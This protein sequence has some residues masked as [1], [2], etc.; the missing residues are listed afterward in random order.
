M[1]KRYANLLTGI[2]TGAD[3]LIAGL[4]FGVS[5]AIWEWQFSPLQYE[6]R[7]F[8][9]SGVLLLLV[10]IVAWLVV[11]DRFHLYSSKR[12]TKLRREYL[13]IAKVTTISIAAGALVVLLLNPLR[14][15]KTFLLIFWLIDTSVLGVSRVVIRGSLRTLR[16]LGYNY[17]N[18]VIIGTNNRSRRLG[19][20]ITDNRGYGLHLLGYIDDTEGPH[21]TPFVNDDVTIIGN[22]KEFEDVLHRYVIDEVYITLPIKSFYKRI[23]EIVALCEECGVPVRVP[24]DL[25]RLKVATDSFAVLDDIPL[26]DISSGPRAGLSF[27][28]KRLI[29]IAVSSFLLILLSPLLLLVALLIKLTSVGPVL[30]RQE[31]L[32]LNRRPFTLLKFRS[33]VADAESMRDELDHLN[34]VTGPVFKIRDDPRITRMG[35]FL[36]KTSLD[37]LPQLFNVLKGEMSLVGPRPPIPAEVEHYDWWQQRRLSMRPGLTCLWQVGGRSDTP[38]REWVNLDLK[39]IDNWSLKLDLA[40]MLRTIPAVIRGNGAA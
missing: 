16:K 4:A 19:K 3:L 31:R 22:L 30:F 40:I 27:Q 9:G 25:F 32:G 36:R 35:K 8:V 21:R 1:L 20:K 2:L 24:S 33:M 11:S 7:A 23:E 6:R 38:F 17:R 39:Y 18:V 29:D 34:E 13:D 5:W 26:L 15:D 14:L 28:I 37:E 12:T 10:Y